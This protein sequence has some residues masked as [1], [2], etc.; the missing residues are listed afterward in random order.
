MQLNRVHSI[1]ATQDN[2][3]Y[4][5][6]CSITDI[7]GASYDTVYVSRPDDPYGLNPSIRKWL[8]ENLEATIEAY[9]PPTSEQ[10]RA[11]MP[12]LTARQLRLGLLEGG[13][14]PSQVSAAIV[15][16]PTGADK[17]RAQIEWEYAVTVGRTHPLISNIGAALG[18]TDEQIDAMWGAA[19]RL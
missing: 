15:A 12:P 8:R 1:R 11:S 17:D 9:V 13:I 10:L 3:V 7:T 6:S 16:M 19:A 14:S 2:D 18:L 4:E 5:V